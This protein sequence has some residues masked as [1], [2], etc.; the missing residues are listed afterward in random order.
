MNYAL[1][2]PIPSFPQPPLYRRGRKGEEGGF[3]GMLPIQGGDLLFLI[4][5]SPPSHKRSSF[6]HRQEFSPFSP[7]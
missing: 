7:Q 3:G 4:S 6:P 2:P 1:A 5:P